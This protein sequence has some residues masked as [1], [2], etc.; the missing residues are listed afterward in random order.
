MAVFI[1]HTYNAYNASCIETGKG[2]VICLDELNRSVCLHRR[3]K[4]FSSSRRKMSLAP[5]FIQDELND[6][7]STICL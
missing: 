1:Q 7:K 3:T 4:R 5:V 2:R 6:L